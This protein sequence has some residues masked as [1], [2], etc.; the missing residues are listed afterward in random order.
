MIIIRKMENV[1]RQTD[2]Q[3]DKKACFFFIITSK[4]PSLR[5]G[6]INDLK[7]LLTI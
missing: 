1:D 7:S 3:T 2:R 4:N 5:S 6:K